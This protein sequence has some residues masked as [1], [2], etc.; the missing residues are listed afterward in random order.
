MEIRVLLPGPEQGGDTRVGRPECRQGLDGRDSSC[1]LHLGA[2]VE[3]LDQGGE[4]LVGRLRAR[5][6]PAQRP[7]GRRSVEIGVAVPP[8]QVVPQRPHEHGD[9]RLG[10]RAELAQGTGR[11][12]PPGDVVGSDDF[13][14]RRDDLAG[15]LR[16]GRERAQE[17][18]GHD[19]R[20][21]AAPVG[22]RTGRQRAEELGIDRLPEEGQQGRDGDG[23]AG[24]AIVRIEGLGGVGPDEP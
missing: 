4:G 2:G 5:G 12:S 24:V 20:I 13:G 22:R 7:G 17:M 19:G 14:E 16:A 10:G 21:P 8:G 18:R 6:D 11:R 15:R 3:G 9:G 23:G 1:E